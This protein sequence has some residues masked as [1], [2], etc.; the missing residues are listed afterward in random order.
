MSAAVAI[1]FGPGAM[2]RT[3]YETPSM[4]SSQAV[5]GAASCVG[6]A[7]SVKGRMRCGD[8]D[9]VEGKE[10]DAV[11]AVDGVS[12]PRARASDEGDVDGGANGAAGVA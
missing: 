2:G 4:T 6:D 11:N 12:T 7:C 1:G 8:E 5:R 10:V 3:V 9:G